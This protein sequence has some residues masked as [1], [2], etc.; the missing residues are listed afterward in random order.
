MVEDRR[1]WWEAVG[2]EGSWRKLRKKAFKVVLG[3]GSRGELAKVE[4]EGGPG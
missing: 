3:G 2:A 1:S 4:E